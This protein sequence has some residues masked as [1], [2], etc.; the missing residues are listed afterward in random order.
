M[1]QGLPQY[2]KIVKWLILSLFRH[3]DSK[4]Y[5]LMIIA[6]VEKYAYFCSR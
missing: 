5:L 1:V 2:L 6:Q 3:D 4:K